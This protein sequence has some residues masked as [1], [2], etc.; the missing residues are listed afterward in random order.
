M[1]RRKNKN[2]AGVASLYGSNIKSVEVEPEAPRETLASFTKK[3]NEDQENVRLA[4][5]R[6][7]EQQLNQSLLALR[8]EKRAALLALPSEELNQI[9]PRFIYDGVTPQAGLMTQVKYAFD[10]LK[11][12]LKNEGITFT[13]VA[14]NKLGIIC[15]LNIGID[16]TSSAVVRQVFDY[17][18][19]LGLWSEDEVIKPKAPAAPQQAKGFDLEDIETL[20]TT[21]REGRSAAE[22]TV[23]E[24]FYSREVGPIWQSW[25]DHMKRDY[26][27]V[28]NDKQSRAIIDFFVKRNLSFHNTR[29]WDTARVALR[30]ILGPSPRT[31]QPMLTRAELLSLQLEDADLDNTDVRREFTRKTRDI[32]ETPESEVARQRDESAQAQRVDESERR[33]EVLSAA[34]TVD[35]ILC[36]ML[37]ADATKVRRRVMQSTQYTQAQKQGWDGGEAYLEEKAKFYEEFYSDK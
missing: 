16:W 19:A 22:S 6:A 31:G 29:N 13:D 2:L 37:V 7:A 12:D 18:D 14:G 5:I 11:D 21:T 4:P 24:F 23:N 27:F 33:A 10:K 30:E 28:P 9:C 15:K 8:A 26:Y 3:Y 34:K 17:C 32:M 1:K 20:D 36:D 35:N 25:C